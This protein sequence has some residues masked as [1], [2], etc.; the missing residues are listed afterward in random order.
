VFDL[1]IMN[2]LQKKSD[3]LLED[4]SEVATQI[5]IHWLPS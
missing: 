2:D 4:L 5:L 1:L 3:K